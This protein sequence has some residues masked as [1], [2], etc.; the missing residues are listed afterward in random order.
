[1]YEDS[2]ILKVSVEGSTAIRSFIFHKEDG[3]LEIEFCSGHT[4]DYP[5]IPESVVRNWMKSESKGKFFHKEIK[6]RVG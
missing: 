2:R 3:R 6:S 4:Y 1:M 5:G